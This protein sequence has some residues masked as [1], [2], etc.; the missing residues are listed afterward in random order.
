M[1]FHPG[2]ITAVIYNSISLLD[3]TIIVLVTNSYFLLE[4]TRK[5][6]TIEINGGFG[7]KPFRTCQ[8]TYHMKKQKSR[9]FLTNNDYLEIKSPLYELFSWFRVNRLGCEQWHNQVRTVRGRK[10]IED[11]PNSHIK[12]AIVNYFTST[13]IYLMDIVVR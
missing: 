4:M 6:V 8:Q 1:R 10:I 11:V 12:H 3:G 5:S 9:I 7:R 2:F 13:S